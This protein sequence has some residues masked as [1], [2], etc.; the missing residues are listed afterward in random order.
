[1][2]SLLPSMFAGS[3]GAVRF[4]RAAAYRVESALKVNVAL[5]RLIT[6]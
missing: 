1:M 4:W 6:P 3:G 2:K 5:E